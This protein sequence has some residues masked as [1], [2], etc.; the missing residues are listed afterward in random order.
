VDLAA[1]AAAAASGAKG[2]ITP[3]DCWWDGVGEM[4]RDLTCDNI[5]TAV[6][7]GF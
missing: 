4:V 3:P 7:S 1:S 5:L 6:G 2:N